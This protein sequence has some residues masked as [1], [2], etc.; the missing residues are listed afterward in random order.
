M[1]STLS[2]QRLVPLLNSGC[3][4][5]SERLDRMNEEQLMRKIRAGLIGCGSVSIIGILPQLD[6]P[7]ARERLELV[8]VCDVVEARAQEVARRYRVPHAY[9]D[10]AEL[11]ARD[12]IDLVLVITPIPLHYRY[13]M[14]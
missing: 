14:Q 13:T 12:D 4:P 6:E 8:A 10:A 7:D 1:S 5:W 3:S 9:T 2:K 11:I